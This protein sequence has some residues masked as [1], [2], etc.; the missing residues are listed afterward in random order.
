MRS[1]AILG[2]GI[3]GLA[4]TYQLHKRG[5]DVVLLEASDRLG[6]VIRS[7][8][9]DGFLI[10]HG[11]NSTLGKGAFTDLLTELQLEPHLLPPA[12]RAKHRF[13]V[14]K[15]GG[16]FELLPLPHSLGEAISTP[17]LPF[18]SKLRVLMEPFAVICGGEDE[19]VESFISRRLGDGVAQNIVAPMLGGIWAAD[20]SRLSCR[21][22][23]P[24]LWQMEQGSGSLSLS[25]LRRYTSKHSAHNKIR[26][27]ITTFTDGLSQL[28]D[29]LT[30]AIPPE[31]IALKTKVES[32][33]FTGQGVRI[34][35]GSPAGALEFE[36]AKCIAELPAAAAASLL[37]SHDSGL[38]E[39]IRAIPYAPVGVLHLAC[40]ATD[41]AH[42]LNGFGCLIPPKYGLA[43]LGVIFSSTL[44][45]GR[46]PDGQRLLTCF[47]GGAKQPALAN[48]DDSAVREQVIAELTQLLGF[49]KPPRVLNATTWAR[50]IP[51]YP[52]KHHRTQALVDA[53]NAEHP[54][55][56]VYGN[57]LRGI[58]LGDRIEHAAVIAQTI[59]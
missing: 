16:S 15:R 32:V 13:L 51:N 30:A 58:S 27:K 33:T 5:V 50:A 40:D 12:D 26:P 6:G 9:K 55:F 20:I 41:V 28:V 21:S 1:V 4:L 53:F 57:W 44:F 3:S 10:E 38:A 11:P 17:I 24:A 14:S 22:A 25:G 59:S 36:A 56:Q 49:K 29:R 47:S 37:E 52:L 39:R 7:E 54:D 23:L 42:P 19:S 35:C 46:A 2:G 18:S 43:T 45:P 31:R 34:V 8:R 48:V